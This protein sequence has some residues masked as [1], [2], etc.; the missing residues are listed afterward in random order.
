VTMRST[1]ATAYAPWYLSYLA[2]AY[3]KLG[4][5][6]DAWCCIAEAINAAEATGERWCDAEV[7][8]AAADVALMEPNPDQVKIDTYLSRALSAA[9]EQGAVSLELRAATSM[10]R[11]RAKEGRHAE[12]SGLVAP[13]LERFT[14]GFGTLDL[15][16]A[17]FLL[18][19]TR[20]TS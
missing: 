9:R 19:T 5:L 20:A 11:L 17:K 16:E 2:I 10:A 13:I 18:Q 12:A 3:A 8:R 1:G 14:E 6:E 7:Y 4:Q 15:I